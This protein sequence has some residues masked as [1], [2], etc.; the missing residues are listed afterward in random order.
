MAV[1][2]SE[3]TKAAVFRVLGISSFT[4]ALD[5]DFKDINATNDADRGM[6]L[7]LYADRNRGS[8]RINSGHFYTSSEFQDRIN[9][10][11][12]LPLP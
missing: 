9:R 1:L 3:A 5:R 7:G 4:E 12:A 8:V 11:K 2:L 6:I 10:V